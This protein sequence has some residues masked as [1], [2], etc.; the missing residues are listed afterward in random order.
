VHERE[1][2][3]LTVDG[4]EFEVRSNWHV[5]GRYEYTW[6]TGPNDGYGFSSQTSDGRGKDRTMHELSIRA[7]LSSIDPATG[8]VS[9]DD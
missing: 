3:F 5:P 9:E 8:Y 4:H 1:P 6:L 2:E 7:F